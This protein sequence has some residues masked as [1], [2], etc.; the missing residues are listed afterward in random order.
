MTQK[1]RIKRINAIPPVKEKRMSGFNWDN[2]KVVFDK[3]DKYGNYE[4]T[5][6]SEKN[7]SGL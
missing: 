7:R 4:D 2:G 1:F 6:T 3:R 5:A